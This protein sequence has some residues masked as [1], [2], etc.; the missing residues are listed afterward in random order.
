MLNNTL[1]YVYI[2]FC[3]SILVLMDTWVAS[4]FCLLWIMLLWA[5]IHKYLFEWVPNVS[6]FEYV[7]VRA[8]LLSHVVILHL[9]FRGAP[10]L[11]PTA[12]THFIFSLSW[13]C[14]LKHKSFQFWWS[15]FIFV[16]LLVY[17]VLYLRNHFPI[18][19][20]DLFLCVLIRVL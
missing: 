19:G 8:K 18:Q 20:Q 11:F 6:S 9:T 1:L 13:Y 16:C 3:F 2:L 5:L 14:P 10:K 17:L 4:I 7:T 12:A 15:T